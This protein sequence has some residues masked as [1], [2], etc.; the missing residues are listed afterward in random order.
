MK[1]VLVRKMNV[2]QKEL[3]FSELLIYQVVPSGQ[4]VITVPGKVSVG[5]NPGTG[6]NGSLS[7]TLF[8]SYV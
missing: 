2:T 1:Y 6:A 8:L 4:N 5:A 7:Q 3:W